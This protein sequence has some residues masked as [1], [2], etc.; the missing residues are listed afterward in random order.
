[1]TKKTLESTLK[2]LKKEDLD[3]IAVDKYTADRLQK[4]QKATGANMKAVLEVASEIL[5]QALGR[6]LIIA[7]PDS[8]MELKI[9][10]FQKYSKLVDLDP[11]KK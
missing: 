3:F 5:E 11:N 1:M 4:I 9:N 7:Q 10:H 6:Q 8:N 2:Q